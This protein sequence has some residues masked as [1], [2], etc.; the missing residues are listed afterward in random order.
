MSEQIA[1]AKSARQKGKKSRTDICQFSSFYF[2]FD[3]EVN[4][5]RA[6]HT[7]AHLKC[8]WLCVCVE[9][10]FPSCD[11]NSN[12]KNDSPQAL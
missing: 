7:E 6:A 8:V 9:T 5:I 12:N 4:Y 10:S 11:S 3:W 1:R 2:R